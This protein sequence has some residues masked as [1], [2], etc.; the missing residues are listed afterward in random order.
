[1]TLFNTSR[2]NY[3]PTSGAILNAETSQDY[4]IEGIYHLCGK[5]QVVADALSRNPTAEYN[6]EE[7]ELQDLPLLTISTTS[8]IG[9]Q[10]DDIEIQ[11]IIDN[12]NNKKSFLLIEGI[13]YHKT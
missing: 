10:D 1:M 8:F 7:D 5:K 13:L 11:Y 9:M 6:P 4:D 12:L 3:D 2:D